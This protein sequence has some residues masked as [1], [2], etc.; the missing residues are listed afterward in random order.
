MLTAKLQQLCGS[1]GGIVDY[2][3]AMPPCCFFILQLDFCMELTSAFSQFMGFVQNSIAGYVFMP[4][5]Y[6]YNSANISVGN[7]VNNSDCTLNYV[8]IYV[9]VSDF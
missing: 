1:L 9:H 7:Q 2:T 3:C 8:L 5:G 6:P 4:T